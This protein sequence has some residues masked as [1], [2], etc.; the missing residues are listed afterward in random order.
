MQEHGNLFWDIQFD[1][2][3]T[4]D[5]GYCERTHVAVCGYDYKETYERAQKL[6]NLAHKAG[7]VVICFSLMLRR[8]D[9][10]EDEALHFNIFKTWYLADEDDPGAFFCGVPEV[11]MKALHCTK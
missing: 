2:G 7:Q 3:A 8:D 1:I 5:A 9:L 10:D 6:Y 11:S 4:K